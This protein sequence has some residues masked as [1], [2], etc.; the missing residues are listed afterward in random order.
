MTN[1]RAYGVRS[2]LSAVNHGGSTDSSLWMRTERRT[3]CISRRARE[4][5]LWR[6]TSAS[7]LTRRELAVSTVLMLACMDSARC[8]EW[9]PYVHVDHTYRA[10]H[11]EAFRRMTSSHSICCSSVGPFPVLRSNVTNAS[12]SVSNVATDSV[13]VS[14]AIRHHASCTPRQPSLL[15][16][17]SGW[18]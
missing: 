17:K 18:M 16:A 3:S 13:S 5:S 14:F 11:F 10:A 9:M 1:R 8:V 4:C 2:C 15:P 7:T 12:N 6:S